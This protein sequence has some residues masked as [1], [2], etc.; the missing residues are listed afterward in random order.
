M[1]FISYTKGDAFYEFNGENGEK[2]IVPSQNVILVDDESGAIAI[3]NTASRKTI[4]LLIT[5]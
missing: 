3:K 5:D 1:R 4:G 2:L